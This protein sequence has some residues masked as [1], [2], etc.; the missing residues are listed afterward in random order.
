MAISACLLTKSNTFFYKTII[1]ELFNS[2]YRKLQTH[3]QVV[4]SILILDSVQQILNLN[5]EG[6]PGVVLRFVH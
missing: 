5:E 3:L 4:Q 1:V 2:Y 6:V